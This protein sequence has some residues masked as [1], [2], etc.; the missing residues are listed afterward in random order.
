MA[1]T[2]TNEKVKKEVETNYCTMQLSKKCKSKEGLL[3]VGEFYTATSPFYI[4][5]RYNICKHCLKEYV[6]DSNGDINTNKLKN[7]FRIYDIPFFEKEWESALYDDKETIGVYFKN[8][9]LN[10]KSQTWLDGDIQENDKTKINTLN[11]DDEQLVARWGE[12]WSMSE[13]QWLERDYTDWL[14]HHDCE[15]L[16]I[17]K[18]VQMICIKEL[19]IRNA[20]QSGK[21]TD[22][23][24]KSLMELMNSSNLTPRTMSAVNETDSSKIYGMWIKDIEQ[25]RPAEYFKDKKLY[26]DYDGIMDYFNRFVLRPMKNLLTGSRDFDKEFMIENEDDDSET[27]E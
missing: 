23:L 5:G 7:I 17:Q 3:P 24:E 14:T 18:L 19:E 2:K 21:A 27:E 20:R 12:C 8:I 16:S 1:K 11:I 4:N 15:K 9:Y 22:K 10:H 26:E 13:L 25:Y 6:Y